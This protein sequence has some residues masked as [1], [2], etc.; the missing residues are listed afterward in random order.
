[1]EIVQIIMTHGQLITM[2]LI[3]L[4]NKQRELEEDIFI[5]QLVEVSIVIKSQE[6][7]NVDMVKEIADAMAA[8][9]AFTSNVTMFNTMKTVVTDALQIGK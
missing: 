4:P 3:K 6:M 5:S 1:M 2:I 8:T 9:Q 7:P